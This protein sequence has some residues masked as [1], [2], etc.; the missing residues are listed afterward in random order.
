MTQENRICATCALV[1]AI[2]DYRMCVLDTLFRRFQ[3]NA[4]CLLRC[5]CEG[6]SIAMTGDLVGNV[7]NGDGKG[8]H[9][10]VWWHSP[11]PVRYVETAVQGPVQTQRF[12]GNPVL[13]QHH[14]NS[15]R[16]WLWH[17]K[18]RVAETY[19]KGLMLAVPRNLWL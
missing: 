16:W 9:I 10:L 4:A 13:F 6:M 1:C 17:G 14:A 18:A 7:I 8:K 15:L 12:T 5:S 3:V 19:L 11:M 2:Y